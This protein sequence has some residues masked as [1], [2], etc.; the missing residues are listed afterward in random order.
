MTMMQEIVVHQ[1]LN[2][3]P[4]GTGLPLLGHPQKKKII[5][6]N[7]ICWVKVSKNEII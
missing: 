5:I 7:I 6:K 3:Q 4:T 1:K 2:L